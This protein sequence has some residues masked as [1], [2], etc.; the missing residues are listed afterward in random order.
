M[1]RVLSITVSAILLFASIGI[2][3]ACA[4]I[5]SLRVG[6]FFS[7]YQTMYFPREVSYN[8]TNTLP[9]NTKGK[10][11]S[12]QLKNEGVLRIILKGR[13]VTNGPVF[14]GLYSDQNMTNEIGVGA[15]VYSGESK[16]IDYSISKA[17]TYYYKIYNNYSAGTFTNILTIDAGFCSSA[18]QNI[19][20]EDN[21]YVG[22]R[23]NKNIYYFKY[24]APRTGWLKVSCDFSGSQ[25]GLYNNKK[26]ALS[27]TDYTRYANYGVKKGKTYY[28]RMYSK[29]PICS[30]FNISA[31]TCKITKNCGTKI[32]KAKKL[33]RNNVR[34][35]VI[36]AESKQS[37]WY[38]IKI[39]KSKKVKA[40]LTG[41]NCGGIKV[42]LYNKRGKRLS[43][44][45]S[46]LSRGAKFTMK[47]KKISAGTYYLKA[48]RFN[49]K[50]SGY[51]NLKWK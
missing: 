41:K 18:E 50:S 38:K 22:S 36:I 16:T 48:S 46:I 17:G 2:D 4:D 26:S 29:Y 19:S 5:E 14:S 31:Y 11:Y 43:N 23:L 35:G 32:K 40:Y 1:K 39:T 9:D 51:Y 3:T 47:S 12:L 13:N 33:K 20:D 49:K 25:I 7:K 42:A 27:Y 37:D 6:D 24:T 45:G 21:L 44:Y 34:L 30:F 28:I 15:S 10:M 8:N